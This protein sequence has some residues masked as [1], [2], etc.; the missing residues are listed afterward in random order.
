MR[1]NP[2]AHP[3]R[4]APRRRGGV[5]VL[6]L[7]VSLV[8]TVMC[9]GSVL[10]LQA[11]LRASESTVRDVKSRTAAQS[12]LELALHNAANSQAWRTALPG[13]GRILS[14]TFA[15]TQVVAAG[16][17][18]GGG[19]PT[20]TQTDPLSFIAYGRS[21]GGMQALRVDADP[22]FTS[23]QVMLQPISV[24][25]SGAFVVT[26]NTDYS[27]GVRME[28]TGN[29]VWPG[30]STSAATK[31]YSNAALDWTENVIA[32]EDRPDAA[33]LFAYY[34]SIAT[35][36]PFA[37]IGGKLEHVIISP[38]SN[39]WGANNAQGVYLIDCAGSTL[40]L[41]Q[42][43]LVGTLVVRNCP[44]LKVTNSCVMEPNASWPTLLVEGDLEIANTNN[45]LDESAAGVNFNFPGTPYL[46]TEDADKLDLLAAELG[47]VFYATR[48]VTVSDDSTVRGVLIAD[49]DVNVNAVLTMRY[50]PPAS[51]PP[52]F[53]KP[54]GWRLRQGTTARV[55]E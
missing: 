2:A 35:A 30:F 6:V 32:P 53:L 21:G 31:W 36:V 17:A 44:L 18:V 7:G 34:Q 48:S 9:V 46:G 15:D 29:A 11:Q 47:G 50:A 38:A 33:T 26:P 25:I 39:P 4:P 24:G 28:F 37:S 8:V 52:G 55:T 16:E 45:D 13:S 14:T 43:R 27:K 22:A 41:S 51:P 40:D 10:A 42:M 20:A 19:A 12:A 5:Y 23:M 3:A 54:D 49:A 1:T